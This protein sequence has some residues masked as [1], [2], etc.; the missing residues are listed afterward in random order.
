MSEATLLHDQLVLD[1][2]VIIKWLRRGEVLA[3]EAL[4]VRDAYLVG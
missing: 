4:A 1:T 3:E 2:S